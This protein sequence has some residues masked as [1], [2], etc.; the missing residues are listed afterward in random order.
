MSGLHETK[1]SFPKSLGFA[2]VV[3]TNADTAQVTAIVDMQGL[4]S[5]E[6]VI[7]TGALTDSDATFTVS[8]AHGDAVDDPDAPAT[9]TDSGAAP[10]ECLVGLEADA[11]FTAANGDSTVK[12]ISYTPGYGAGKRYARLTVTPAGNN[13]GAAPLACIAIKKPYSFGA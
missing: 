7:A 2:P 11:S 9:I 6:W 8:V 5:V 1:S 4:E 13:S 10:D 3:L 12:S